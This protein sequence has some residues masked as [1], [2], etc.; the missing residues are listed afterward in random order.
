M[1]TGFE[2]STFG[3][4][5]IY[6]GVVFPI[7]LVA[8]IGFV[9]YFSDP[10]MNKVTFV[11]VVLAYFC[12]FGILFTVPADVATVIT[13]RKVEANHSISAYVLD[14]VKLNNVYNAFFVAILILTSLVLVFLEYFDTDGY[15]TVMSRFLS[16]GKRMLIDQTVSI[17]AALVVL[18]VLIG[19][20]VVPADAAALELSLIIVTNIIY[21]TFLMFLMGYGLI[22]FPRGL[23]LQGSL[24]HSLTRAQTIAYNDFKLLS[25]SQIVVGQVVANILKTKAEKEIAIG[26]DPEVSKAMAVL[27]E[28]CPDDFRSL[29]HGEVALDK[30]HAV[31]VHVL[32]QLRTEL[33]VAVAAYRVAEARV[34]TTKNEAYRLMNIE[35]AKDSDERVI[36]WTVTGKDST[37][38]EYQWYIHIRPWIMRLLS[39]CALL[40]SVFSMIG[41]IA[42]MTGKSQTG[43]PYYMAV[44]QSGSRWVA[45][46]VFIMTTLGYASFVAYWSLLQMSFGGKMILVFRRSSGYCMSFSSRMCARLAAPVAFFYLGWLAEA[47]LIE[48][49]WLYKQYP[50]T[51]T[52]RN[53]TVASVHVIDQQNVTT[54]RYVNETV[55]INNDFLM[56]SSFSNFYQ[57]YKIG[58]FKTAF[59]SVFP[60]MLLVVM[61]LVIFNILNWILVKLRLSAFQMGTLVVPEDQLAEGKRKLEQY[62]VSLERTLQ[63][64]ALTAKIQENMGSRNKAPGG[65]GSGGRAALG[66]STPDSSDV[67]M[68]TGSAGSGGAGRVGKKAPK[69]VSSLLHGHL[70][71]DL[72]S[73]AEDKDDAHSAR[74]AVL[75]RQPREITGTVERKVYGGLL[76]MS[77]SWKAL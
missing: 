57:I 21:E 27:V 65:S 74:A 44:H 60:V 75:A 35:E 9:Y 34:D 23:W 51:V 46:A 31:T 49:D 38:W 32:A 15:F 62:K 14:V 66:T 26:R 64:G 42:T 41:V 19:E 17:V 63:R 1:A 12:T 22:E 28:E 76:G 68:A 73:G 25:N 69:G 36:H 40:L 24:A 50:P 6:I 8:C 33:N 55:L 67:E 59:R 11:M 61:G 54:Y 4:I 48:G 52:Y 29:R 45:L 5:E 43:S 58:V 10:K 16:A 13:D 47:G 71:S 37:E 70:R 30:D 18:G 56:R 2:T 39:L 7:L 77:R 53:T 72:A 3:Y 20:K